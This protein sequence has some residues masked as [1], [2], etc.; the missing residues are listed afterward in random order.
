MLVL[1]NAKRKPDEITNA[2]LRGRQGL[3]SMACSEVG[4]RR[5][6]AAM[7]LSGVWPG[8]YQKFPRS[9]GFDPILV[10]HA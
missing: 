4:V 6:P 7:K 3:L 5:I 2:L 8:L 9:W 10:T 1:P